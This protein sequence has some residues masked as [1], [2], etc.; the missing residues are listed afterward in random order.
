MWT[1]SH[2]TILLVGNRLQNPFGLLTLLLISGT[3]PRLDRLW[4]PYSVITGSRPICCVELL[5]SQL[6]LF[7]WARSLTSPLAIWAQRNNLQKVIYPPLKIYTNFLNFNL[8][9]EAAASNFSAIISKF[10]LNYF[11]SFFSCTVLFKWQHPQV[12][13]FCLLIFH[14]QPFISCCHCQQLHR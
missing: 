11:V 4:S 8:H 3:K 1:A 6:E 7:N 10:H 12:N 9:T 13:E 14:R 5:F 2:I